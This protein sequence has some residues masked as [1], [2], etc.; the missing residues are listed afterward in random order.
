MEAW[1]FLI[2][3]NFFLLVGFRGALPDASLERDAEQLLRFHGEL[4]GQ[5]LEYLLAESADDHRDGLLGI[6]SRGE[7]GRAAA[8]QLYRSDDGETWTREA[9]DFGATD[10]LV[11]S[12]MGGGLE[13]ILPVDGAIFIE[14]SG[15]GVSPIGRP[16]PTLWRTTA[17]GG[18]EEVPIGFTEGGGYIED[19]VAVDGRLVLVGSLAQGDTESK[20]VVWLQS[21]E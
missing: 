15:W 16:Y 8:R 13:A 14:G 12:G 3:S 21:G 1:R 17:D 20:P 7:P 6:G 18:W 2:S 11:E 4:H 9:F 5:I 19:L 10:E